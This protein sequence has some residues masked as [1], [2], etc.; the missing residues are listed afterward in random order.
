[1]RIRDSSVLY[2]FVFLHL[3]RLVTAFE[4]GVGLVYNITY[5]L[6]A[7]TYILLYICIPLVFTYYIL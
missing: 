2:N 7:Y 6:T 1:M 5:S 4:A 3:S